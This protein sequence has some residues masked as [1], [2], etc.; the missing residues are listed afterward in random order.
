M[1]VKK[2]GTVARKQ[3]ATAVQVTS[4][5]P[6]TSRSHRAVTVQTAYVTP[7]YVVT[8]VRTVQMAQ[9]IRTAP[10]DSLAVRS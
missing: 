5:S 4:L 6:V 1:H 2:N 7:A 10:T 9:S 3:S 8:N